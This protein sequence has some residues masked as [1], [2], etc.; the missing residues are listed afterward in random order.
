MQ[1]RLCEWLSTNYRSLLVIVSFVQATVYTKPQQIIHGWVEH[2]MLERL[3][4]NTYC[5]EF[6][7]PEGDCFFVVCIQIF[8][9]PV[10]SHLAGL[11]KA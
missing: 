11:F 8:A 5:V 6:H 4:C 1:D 2:L 10:R 7:R 9:L 3:V